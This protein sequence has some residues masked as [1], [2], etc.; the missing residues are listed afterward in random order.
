MVTT[1]G[2]LVVFAPVGTP[3]E[4]IQQ[5]LDTYHAWIGRKSAERREAMSLIEPGR[6]YYLG[7]AYPV[8]LVDKIREAVSLS[9]NEMRL[10][11]DGPL[12][13]VRELLG[14]WYWQEAERLVTGKGEH[15]A[16]LMKLR[17]NRVEIRDWRRRWGEC[18]PRD[19]LLRLN[20]RLVLLPVDVLNYV[21]AHEVTHLAVPGHPP[22]FWRKLA[23]VMPDWQARR[24]WLNRFGSP[25]LLWNLENVALEAGS[26]KGGRET[27][28]SPGHRAR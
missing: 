26:E 11:R 16:R 17:V 9:E 2:E 25:F 19:G 6:A 18:R 27:P 3:P 13:K 10:G 8:R 5:A 1:T 22:R 23:K 12:E 24:R 4:T 7:R 20:W 28:G 21:V 14:N 15:Y